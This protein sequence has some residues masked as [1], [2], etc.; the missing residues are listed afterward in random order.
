MGCRT[1]FFFSSRRRH[2]RSLCDWSSDVCSSDLSTRLST[3]R[4]MWS[5]PSW[6]TVSAAAGASSTDR[7][8]VVYGKRVDITR[9]RRIRRRE[10]LS[11]G[12][13]DGHLWLRLFSTGQAVVPCDPQLVD[14]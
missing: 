14:D 11:A 9:H 5:S 13:T 12:S 10:M 3:S 2:T 4:T 1:Y 6:P 8:S 7:K